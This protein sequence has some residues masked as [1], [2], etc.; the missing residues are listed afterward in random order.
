[1]SKGPIQLRQGPSLSGKRGAPVGE[2][3][4]V[5]PNCNFWQTVVGSV[6][7]LAPGEGIG[8]HWDVAMEMQVLAKHPV[9]KARISEN[10]RYDIL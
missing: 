1:M 4:E 8:L 6:G 7:T 9:L 3:E 5:D 2:L 10:K